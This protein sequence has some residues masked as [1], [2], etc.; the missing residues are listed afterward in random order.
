MPDLP[1]VLDEEFAFF[2]GYLAG[3]GFVASGDQDHRVGVTVAHSSYLLSEMPALFKRL[4]GE[5]MHVHRQQKAHDASTTFWVDNRA[6][7]DFLILNGLHKLSSTQ[8]RVPRLIRQ[9]PPYVVGAYLRGLFEAENR[10]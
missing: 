7:K 10:K 6:V 8:V 5:Q 4:F 1:A 2:L 3:D 9:S